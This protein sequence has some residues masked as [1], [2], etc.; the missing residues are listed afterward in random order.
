MRVAERIVCVG[1]RAVAVGG[2]RGLRSVHTSSIERASDEPDLFLAV[3]N[4][5]VATT[6][7]YYVE[8][9]EKRAL[10]PALSDCSNLALAVEANH[11]HHWQIDGAI[12][13][14]VV[15]QPGKVRPSAGDELELCVYLGSDRILAL[16]DMK[17]ILL[18]RLDLVANGAE[19]LDDLCR[20]ANTR[21]RSDVV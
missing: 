14:E 11:V 17:K 4:R 7:A 8:L 19:V 18:L 20:T 9:F 15:V 1:A 2:V 21:G 16:D 10:V 12:S 3:T 6:L 13:Q 5:P